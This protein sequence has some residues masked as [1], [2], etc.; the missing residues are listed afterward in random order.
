V[1]GRDARPLLRV[2]LLGAGGHA[3]DILGAIEA[4]NA[5]RPTF[6]EV[7]LFDDAPGALARFDGRNARFGG[8]IG[9]VARYSLDGCLIAVG[10]PQVRE[11]IAA[12][13]PD[14]LVLPRLLH[15]TAH[16]GSGVELGAGA[17]VLAL[18]CVSP[19]AR[20]GRHVCVSNGAIVGHDT[21]VGD[22]ASVMPG[23]V[24][25]GE[26][27]VGRGA[28]IGTN[29]TV[30][31]GLRIGAGARVGAGATVTRDV[32]PGETVVGTPARPVR[33][34]GPDRALTSAGARP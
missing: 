12:R 21:V 28:L 32:A 26:V 29:A 5:Q 3:S 14:A 22:F 6:A 30:L 17:V 33:S 24:L 19:L 8:P 9:H 10:Y 16:L 15:P 25:S 27:T 31:E 34:A 13:V 23:A 4:V 2:A 18:A 20:L 11:R 1:S 7:R